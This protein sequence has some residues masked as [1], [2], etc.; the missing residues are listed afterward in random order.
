M[1]VLVTA[2]PQ[3]I[4]LV[5]ALMARLSE[6]GGELR[7]YLEDDDYDLRSLGC[8]IAVGALDDADSL[9]GAL[10]NVHTFIPVLA[11]PWPIFD[12]SLTDKFFTFA[13]TVTAVAEAGLTE[14]TI[15]PISAVAQGTVRDRLEALARRFEAIPSHCVLRTGFTWGPGR[16]LYESARSLDPA[17][18]VSALSIEDLVSAIAAADDFEELTGTFEIGGGTYEVGALA[19][20]LEPG[21]ASVG[22]GMA[23]LIPNGELTLG[24]SGFAELSIQMHPLI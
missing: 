1:P 10:T 7:C 6:G 22:P 8:K 4:D 15:V 23:N 14:Q 18:N 2:M 20:T 3:D 12:A 16:P 17:L 24:S 21:E 9:E 11:D 19:Q 5:R 13:E